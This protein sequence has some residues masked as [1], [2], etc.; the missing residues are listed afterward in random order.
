MTSKIQTV[1]TVGN[2]HEYLLQDPSALYASPGGVITVSATAFADYTT[3]GAALAAASPGDEI[4]VYGGTYAENITLDGSK[5][6]RG[7][8]FAQKVIISGADTTGT[9]VTFAGTGTLREITVIGPSVG[10]NAAIDATALAGGENVVLYNVSVVGG[11][12]A[13]S[14]GIKGAGLG[15]VLSLEEGLGGYIHGSG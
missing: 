5:R 6:V 4:V 1:S 14:S 13:T 3:I 7:F 10:S 11:G 12:S 9:R 8:G 15:N 2:R